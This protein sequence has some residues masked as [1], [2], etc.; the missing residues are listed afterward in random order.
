VGELNVT[1]TP[2][3]ERNRYVAVD[4]MY[5][6]AGL[7]PNTEGAGGD[8][9][10]AGPVERKVVGTGREAVG[11]AATVLTGEEK[12]TDF[13]HQSKQKKKQHIT[14]IATPRTAR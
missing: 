5:L 13:V 9:A 14:T 2:Q 11:R 8:D 6:L 1:S 7:F 10:L 4:I 12:A 3:E